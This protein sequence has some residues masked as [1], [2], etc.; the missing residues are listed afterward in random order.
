[1]PV[2]DTREPVNTASDHLQSL[3]L[4]A[5]D[6]RRYL[7]AG[8][9]GAR[10]RSIIV[11]AGSSHQIV[12]RQDPGDPWNPDV[13]GKRSDST[14]TSSRQDQ[15]TRWN[16]VAAK[17]TADKIRPILLFSLAN[18]AGQKRNRQTHVPRPL[19]AWNTNS[20]CTKKVLIRPPG[21]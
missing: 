21:S 16:P 3:P 4:P 18:L 2:A 17:D 20:A 14:K 7:R 9:P 5:R 13:A 8:G 11:S 12:P 10:T 15:R 6:S 1:M 19:C